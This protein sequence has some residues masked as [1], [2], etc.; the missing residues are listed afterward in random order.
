MGKAL[1]FLG[2][3]Q[4]GQ[5]L[6]S[7]IEIKKGA[8]TDDQWFSCPFH[9][10][11]EASA[12]YSS[13]KDSFYCFGC[14]SSGDLIRFYTDLH[15][16]DEIE[17]F[18]DFLHA[19]CP[20]RLGNDLTAPKKAAPKVVKAAE[21]QPD[22]A[23][24]PPAKWREKADQVVSDCAK[25]LQNMPEVLKML[26]DWGIDAETARL[27]RIGWNDKDRFYS[28]TSM[29]LPWEPSKRNPQKERKI[30]WPKG[31]VFASFRDGLPAKVKIR[32]VE[33]IAG[34]PRYMQV[35][36]GQT[37]SGLH[38]PYLIAGRHDYKIWVIV[39]TDRDA[40]LIWSACRGLNIGAMAVGSAGA[41]PDTYAAKILE[42]A[43]LILCALDGD[44]AGRQYANSFW[45]DEFPIARRWPVPARCGKDVGDAVWPL[46]LRKIT[47]F[48]LD[49]FYLFGLAPFYIDVRA[50]IC[51]GIPSH[52]WRAVKPIKTIT[53]TVKHGLRSES[54]VKGVLRPVLPESKPRKVPGPEKDVQA[55][56]RLLKKY[57]LALKL[58]ADGVT[59]VEKKSGWSSTCERN[60]QV[61][62]QVSTLVFKSDEVGEMLDMLDDG[63]VTATTVLKPWI[64]SGWN[65]AEMG[66]TNG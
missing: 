33:I 65:P 63:L 14:Q 29:G 18:K 47:T 3:D 66:E 42:N 40:Y 53:A 4:C 1:D 56:S 15:N 20:D 64:D 28:V 44:R 59:I 60:W 46:G 13:S 23:Y 37:P 8:G 32:T 48:P 45:K 61:M 58:S 55:L 51:A 54:A 62:K 31:L 41:R 43:E 49:D 6:A 17:G 30:W 5:I 39:E 21:W 22:G 19:Y 27:C 9:A 24:L 2:A 38:A 25:A 16:M 34:V 12:H 11:S 7:L 35:Y 26:A 52:I 36:A 50:W 57:P 10:D